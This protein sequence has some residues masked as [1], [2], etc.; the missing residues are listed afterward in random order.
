LELR[1]IGNGAAVN[2]EVDDVRVKYAENAFAQIRFDRFVFLEPNR[3]SSPTQKFAHLRLFVDNEALAPEDPSEFA[4]WVIPSEFRSSP[5]SFLR[6]H[7]KE[8]KITF[9]LRFQDVDGLRYEQ[10]AT[11]QVDGNS[12]RPS[13]IGM[14]TMATKN[15]SCPV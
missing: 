11:M 8:D 4:T 12:L 5:V 6:E 15:L 1:N 3:D 13:K 7:T 14:V 2:I 9:V 10:S